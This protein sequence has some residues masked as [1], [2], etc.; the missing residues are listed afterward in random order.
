MPSRREET[1]GRIC[2]E[3]FPAAAEQTSQCWVQYLRGMEERVAVQFLDFYELRNIWVDVRASPTRDGGI[4][5]FFRDVS[6]GKNNA[7]A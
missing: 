7:L 1:R 4:A 3:V 5:V 6:A 2:W